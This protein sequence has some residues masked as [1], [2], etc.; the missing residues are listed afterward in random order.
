MHTLPSAEHPNVALLRDGF[1]AFDKGD[2]DLI[3]DL[4]A[5]GVVHHVR[6]RGPLSGAYRTPEEILGFYV[7]LFDL[8]DGTFRAE[9]Y[10]LTADDAHGVA[11][12]HTYAER[13]RGRV[14]SGRAV[15]IF[16]FAAGRIIEIR[17]LAEDQYADDEFWS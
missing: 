9:P 17:S 11:L 5:D 7:R 13:P 4:L 1:A 16:R 8:S 3:R 10:S 12:V 14:L 15:H 2:M 6:G